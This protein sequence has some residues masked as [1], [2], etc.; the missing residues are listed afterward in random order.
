VRPFLLAGG[1]ALIWFVQFQAVGVDGE[2]PPWA[3]AIVAV[4]RLVVDFIGAW[5]ALSVVR[6]VIALARLGLIH[7]RTHRRQDIG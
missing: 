2:A 3:F 1:L 5:V 4:G 6:L 7:L